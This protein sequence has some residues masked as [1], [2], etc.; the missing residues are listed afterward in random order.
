MYNAI[1]AW[2]QRAKGTTRTVKK[3]KG[4]GAHETRR[5][6]ISN[7]D[8]TYATARSI[9]MFGLKPTGFMDNAIAVTSAKVQQR[10]GAALAVDVLDGLK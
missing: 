2:I 4:F 10:L 6:K 9:K 1:D 3:Y 8:N 5:K 7:Y